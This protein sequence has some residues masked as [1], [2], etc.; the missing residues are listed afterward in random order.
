MLGKDD[1]GVV[2]Q[3]FIIKYTI[4]NLKDILKENNRRDY[5]S[6]N[7]KI[8]FYSYKRFIQ[9]AKKG[10][11]YGGD[12]DDP[13]DTY[14]YEGS[15]T[16][17]SSSSDTGSNFGLGTSSG[18]I[19]CAILV[20]SSGGEV[21]GL[22]WECG[23]GDSGL[24]EVKGGDDDCY[25]SGGST[26]GSSGINDGNG[27]IDPRE[28][29]CEPGHTFVDGEC[30]PDNLEEDKI[31]SSELIGKSKCLN[32]KLNENGNNFVNDLLK[33]FK[34]KSEFDINIKS[35]KNVYS[36]NRKEYV[37]A[38]TSYKKGDR[39]INI[40]ISSEKISNMSVLSGI[41]T[42]LHE[43]IHADIYRKLNTKDNQDEDEVKEFKETYL[44]YKREEHHNSMATLYIGSMTQS[45]KAIH[46]KILSRE[47]NY[48]LESYGVETLDNIYESLAWQ[49]LKNHKLDAWKNL[50]NDTTRINNT[51]KYYSHGLTK[52]CPK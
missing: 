18:G 47:Y 14:N 28:E 20:W 27:P 50:G 9:K 39:N 22:S 31:D 29:E 17:G 36:K 44:K 41:R 11:R 42:I 48:L 43:Y 51:L 21:F 40:Q 45:L 12:Y 4:Y 25:G 34:G 2:K 10:A 35:V 38:I 3:P 6:M 15:S 1:E 49:G 23:D 32:D 30:I 8:E 37:N 5:T 46:K 26:G 24:L 52:D 13:C 33:K 7:A 16:G 19:P